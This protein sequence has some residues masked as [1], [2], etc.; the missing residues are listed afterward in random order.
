[1]SPIPKPPSACEPPPPEAPRLVRDP[2]VDVHQMRVI[3]L[4]ILA[5][6]A[7]I[8]VGFVV[9]RSLLVAVPVGVVIGVLVARL[10]G[11]LG[12]A[13]G[14]VF[15]GSGRTTP[16]PADHSRAHSLAVRG[17]ID[18][19]VAEYERALADDPGDPQ[20]YVEI[21]RLSRDGLQ[22]P[23]EALAWLRRARR[24]RRLTPAQD[25]LIVR[26]I[27]ELCAHRLNEPLRAA[28]ELSQLASARPDTP[29]GAWARREL[30]RIRAE[31][32]TF[33]HDG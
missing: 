24:A 12:N 21:A 13:A 15:F 20:P 17:Q 2:R 5:G 9:F 11:V 3:E 19:A 30:E 32:L 10:P 4:G 31:A 6:L 23:A 27:A 16:R 18:A 7:G 33:E 28:P 14:A 8:G 25:A 22:Q 1:M 29:D 26:E